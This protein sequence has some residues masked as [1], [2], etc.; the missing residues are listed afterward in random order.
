MSLNRV[1]FVTD[2]N[3]TDDSVQNLNGS[4]TFANNG[5]Q[6]RW[7]PELVNFVVFQGSAAG[8]YS[9]FASQLQ[10]NTNM[11]LV[12][13]CPVPV[14][15]PSQPQYV[16][17]ASSFAIE[18]ALAPAP[19]Q[20]VVD[21][22]KQQFAALTNDD[23]LRSIDFSENYFGICGGE[24]TVLNCAQY[25]Y[26]AFYAL[27]EH[28]TGKAPTIWDVLSSVYFN[29]LGLY[30]FNSARSDAA[31]QALA[32]SFFSGVQNSGGCRFNNDQFDCSY[33]NMIEWLS[34]TAWNL[35]TCYPAL[36][37]NP[38]TC[39]SSTGLMY[40]NLLRTL[41]FTDASLVVDIFNSPPNPGPQFDTTT[42][43]ESVQLGFGMFAYDRHVRQI[44]QNITSWRTGPGSQIP[45]KWGNIQL[46]PGTTSYPETD[47]PWRRFPIIQHN[48]RDP[49]NG[50][51]FTT[52]DAN[53]RYGDDLGEIGATQTLD[54]YCTTVTVITD[55][56]GGFP[57]G[58]LANCP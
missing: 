54:S 13:D 39:P 18:N 10:N 34:T 15:V 37:T 38:N 46:S 57:A 9:P 22:L 16:Y 11:S 23:E 30:Q 26:S 36:D 51:T 8:A 50:E 40:T 35:H 4:I 29:E 6:L 14:P 2:N 24:S 52:L 1:Y 19:S 3:Q 5:A 48:H 41:G 21:A 20:E 56:T 33:L 31:L 32:R 7:L 45:S 55:V 12:L 43:H 44:S 42:F 27:F 25:T 47:N 17:P 49:N 53:N 28:Y 58:Q